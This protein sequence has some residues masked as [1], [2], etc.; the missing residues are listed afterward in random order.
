MHVA[1]YC[2]KGYVLDHTAG[3]WTHTFGGG[4]IPSDAH[5]YLPDGKT[6]TCR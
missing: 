1:F 6:L 3:G 2:E 5:I 4:F